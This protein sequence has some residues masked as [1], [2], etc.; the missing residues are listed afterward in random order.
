MYM[1]E[2]FNNCFMVLRYVGYHFASSNNCALC[3]LHEYHLNK[4]YGNAS[5]NEDGIYCHINLGK[6][7]YTVIIVM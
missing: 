3:I 4:W 7:G 6:G 2:G 1:C 5:E